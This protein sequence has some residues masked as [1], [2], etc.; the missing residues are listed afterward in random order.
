ML[1]HAR[2]AIIG[3]AEAGDA[4]PQSSPSVVPAASSA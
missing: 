3:Q 4:I 1:E 2:I